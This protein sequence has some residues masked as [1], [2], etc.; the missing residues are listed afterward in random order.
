MLIDGSTSPSKL[1]ISL[2]YFFGLGEAGFIPQTVSNAGSG[3]V[4]TEDSLTFSSVQLHNA[5]M[6][7]SFYVLVP[8][9]PEGFIP[10]IHQISSEHISPCPLCPSLH[11][12]LIKELPFSWAL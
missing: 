12:V 3:L 8:P 10:P 2:T 11:T 1:H 9:S 5:C 6:Y 4:M 7:W